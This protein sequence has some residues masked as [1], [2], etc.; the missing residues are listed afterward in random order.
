MDI[1]AFGA[2]LVGGAIVGTV[3]GTLLA[4]VLVEFV[5]IPVLEWIFG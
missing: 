1:L 5:V 2:A 4:I 3:I